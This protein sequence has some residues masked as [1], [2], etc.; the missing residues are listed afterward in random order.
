[1]NNITNN[2]KFQTNGNQNNSYNK[3]KPNSDQNNLIKDLKDTFM[4]TLN[5]TDEVFKNLIITIEKTVND[6]KIRE[7]ST[8]NINNTYSEFKE[9][10]EEIRNKL[11]KNNLFEE[12]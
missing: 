2:N 5:G 3:M 8:Q 6:Q 11:S 7:E 4:E 10:L 12:E 1:M 9:S